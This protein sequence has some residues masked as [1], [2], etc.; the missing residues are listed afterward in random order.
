[1]LVRPRLNPRL[2]DLDRG[3]AVLRPRA[4]RHSNAARTTALG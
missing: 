3:L 4:A 2:P 1:M